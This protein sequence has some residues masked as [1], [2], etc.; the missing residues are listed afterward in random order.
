MDQRPPKS[1]LLYLCLILGLSMLMRWDGPSNQSGGIHFW[2]SAQTLQTFEIWQEEGLFTYGGNLVETYPEACNR[3]QSVPGHTFLADEA[4]QY[5]YTSYP[6]LGLLLPYALHQALG[7]NASLTSL[8]VWSLLLYTLSVLFLFATLWRFQAN[9]WALLGT[10]AFAF[11]PGPLYYLSHIYF[12]DMLALFWLIAL[13]WAVQAQLQEKNMWFWLAV[14]NF[15]ACY[16]EWLGMLFA[17][18]AGILLSQVQRSSRWFWCFGLSG[19][20]ALA[21]CLWQYSQIAGLEALLD[22]WLG[23]LNTQSGADISVWQGLGAGFVLNQFRNYGVLLVCLGGFF[24]FLFSHTYRERKTLS[25]P[26]PLLLSLALIAPFLHQ[27]TFLQFGFLHDFAGLKSGPFW[28]LLLVWLGAQL[29]LSQK[30]KW[31]WGLLWGSLFLVYGTYRYHFYVE[32]IHTDIAF[33]E[34]IHAHL[35]SQAQPA[36][37]FIDVEPNPVLHYYTKHNLSLWTD[38]LAAQRIMQQTNCQKAILIRTQDFA[39]PQF[40]T[41]SLE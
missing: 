16:T 24:L 28:V 23:R 25:S 18:V 32:V 21:L 20:A 5:Y 3:Y 26:W 41:L 4:G 34:R 35:K 11:S 33:G 38:T 22:Q 27:L 40:Q 2:L 6:P 14:L 29:D 13:L 39:E 15:C 7:Q 1:Y 30:S 12:S 37:Y 19:L 36:L 17:L 31:I 10:A 8:R 9:Y